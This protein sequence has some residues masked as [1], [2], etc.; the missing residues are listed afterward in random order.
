MVSSMTVCTESFEI[1]R[2]VITTILI[3]MVNDE[4]AY[5]FIAAL[6]ATNLSLSFD[7][8]QKAVALISPSSSRCFTWLPPRF[9]KALNAAEVSFSGS[10]VSLHEHDAAESAFVFP[11][12]GTFASRPVAA[13]FVGTK[14]RLMTILLR[15]GVS[16]LLAFK[17]LTFSR[18]LIP[19]SCAAKLRRFPTKPILP[20]E[21]LC[22]PSTLTLWCSI[23]EPCPAAQLR[24]EFCPSAF[25][26]K[27][28]FLTP[29]THIAGIHRGFAWKFT[30]S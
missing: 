3:A 26:A 10:R 7:R 23:P 9:S 24:T 2:L 12:D 25:K 16:A 28:F 17:V 15:K 27:E 4:M 1:I 11:R 29:H 30:G 6:F 5:V 22:T 14:C 19:A 20:R 21:L 8:V 18:C 13:T